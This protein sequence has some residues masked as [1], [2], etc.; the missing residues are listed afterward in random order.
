MW[1]HLFYPD[2]EW[3]EVAQLLLTLQKE[4]WELINSHRHYDEYP[5]PTDSGTYY[6][7]FFKRPQKELYLKEKAELLEK[8]GSTGILFDSSKKHDMKPSLGEVDL[9]E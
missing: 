6:D 5:D 7:L 9:N 1:E 3:K 8:Y 2:I 4:G